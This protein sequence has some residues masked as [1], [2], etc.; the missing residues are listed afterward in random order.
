MHYAMNICTMVV[1]GILKAREYWND[2]INL[3]VYEGCISAVFGIY[4]SF[5]LRITE[6]EYCCLLGRCDV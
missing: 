3:A 6:C 1:I 2:A 4:S 5:A